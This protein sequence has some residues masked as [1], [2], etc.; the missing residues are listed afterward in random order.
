MFWVLFFLMMSSGVRTLFDMEAIRGW[1]ANLQ[2]ACLSGR[3]ATLFPA[4]W[5]GLVCGVDELSGSLKT[6]LSRT[7][8]V[9]LF[10]VSGTHLLVFQ[11]LL[12]RLRAP[13]PVL[14]AGLSAYTLVSGGQPPALRSLLSVL[15]PEPERSS[16]ADLD[17]LKV[18]LLTLCFVPSWIHSY[19]LR[20]SWMA[21]LALTISFGRGWRKSFLTAIAV[22][23]LLAPLL[24]N[25]AHPLTW[26]LNLLVAPVFGGLGLPLALLGFLGDV[27][28]RPFD[29]F[30]RAFKDFIE[31]I[32]ACFPTPTAD[33]A[34][35]D[36]N[37]WL[38]IIGV[39]VSLHLFTVGRRREDLSLGE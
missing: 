28:I 21:A 3:P 19:S 33:F 12:V 25:F 39:H 14:L 5:A 30:M 9:H 11:K 23:A 31:S 17:V 32:S 38:W 10:V 15:W 20:L 35:D 37:Q 24:M 29:L 27:F 36:W 6:D 34:A 2:W 4:E 26:I 13:K 18:G 16:R 1:T 22:W 8:L 7:G